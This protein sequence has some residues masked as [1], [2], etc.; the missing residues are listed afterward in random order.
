M[1]EMPGKTEA[2]SRV[3]KLAN[4][5]IRVLNEAGIE[6][7]K[8]TSIV[9]CPRPECSK[10]GVCCARNRVR[11]CGALT[12]GHPVIAV[13]AVESFAAAVAGMF[14]IPLATLLEGIREQHGRFLAGSLKVER[15]P[16]DPQMKA[17]RDLADARDRAAGKG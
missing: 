1:P 7:A 16:D 11:D 12:F 15:D 13:M 3:T 17:I 6:L 9:G 8:G 5:L 4:D 2:G 10:H 14:G